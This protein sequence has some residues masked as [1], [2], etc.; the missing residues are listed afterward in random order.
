[1]ITEDISDIIKG[2]VAFGVP[3]T[4]FMGVPLQEWMYIVSICAA[5]LLILERMPSAYS[6]IKTM[7]E[8]IYDRFKK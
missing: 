8:K 4:S 7:K 6:S 1:M 5:F 2:S 3:T